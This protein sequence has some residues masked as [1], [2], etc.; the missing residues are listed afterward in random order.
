M[1]GR[2]VRLIL[3]SL[4]SAL[5]FV[6]A[7]A[8]DSKYTRKNVAPQYW[9]AYEYCYDLNRPITELRWQ[10]NI[11]WMAETFLDWGYDMISNDGWIEAAQTINENGYI[12]KYNSGWEHGFE[13]WNEYIKNKGMKVGV[14]YNPLWMTAA[15]YDKDCPVLG[16]T[17]TARRI[18]GQY[19]FNGQ[20]HWV[21]V[22]KAGAEEWV[23]GY[24]RYFIDLGVSFLRVDFLENY[25]NHYGTE[26]Y[27]KA[28][29]WIA[30]EAGDDLFI[31]L[32]M[33]NSF[34]QAATEIPYGDMFRISDD[35]FAGD[36]N[37]VSDRRRGQVKKNWPMYANVFDGFVAFSEVSGPG[38]I[39]MDG[40][41][42]RLNKLAD[43]AERQFLFSLMIMAGSP[44]AIADQYDTA[45]DDVEEIYKNEEL[46][47]LHKNGFY[48]KPLSTDI[49][50]YE[51]SSRW[52]GR[53]PDGDYIVGLFN[54]EDEPLQYGID[55]VT[56]LGIAT[57]R[58]ENVRDL[59]THTELGSMK[60]K[61]ETTLEPHHCRIV[62][63]SPDLNQKKSP[64]FGCSSRQDE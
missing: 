64:F 62:R 38:K 56:E 7:D 61:Y 20:L 22:D 35:C 30:E 39:M 27:E 50:D 24:V 49:H 45:T 5:L 18:A 10:C 31:S 40:D 34:N 36:W 57:G 51:N 47:H 8:R 53:L 9:I 11:D 15:A 37:F 60:N 3:V 52:V 59:W 14:Y 44:L 33:P 13:Y 29:R 55:F 32:V 21:D 2:V 48:A 1:V 25:E 17:T 23:K 63:I 4:A 58:A 16:T 43:N 42:M 28:L 46:L 12:T 19:S 6:N 54:R 41:F 26:R